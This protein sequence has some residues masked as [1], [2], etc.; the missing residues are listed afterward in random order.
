MLELTPHPAAPPA[1]ALAVAAEAVRLPHAVLELRYR[2]AGDLGALLIPAIAAPVRTDGLWRR[3]CL[4]AFV[5]GHGDEGYL[6]LNLSPSTEWA[7]YRFDRYRE[8]MRL[9]H[10][11]PA[12]VEVRSDEGVLDLSAAI[13]VSAADLPPHA[14]WQIGLS[15]VI[16]E[17]GGAISY[18]A[19]ANPPGRPDFHHRDGFV[20]ELPPA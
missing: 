20:L 18:W 13:D 7:A 14:P 6:E 8:G 4:E 2:L 11:A 9:G 19:L 12:D 5:R 10:S 3:T 17:M 1:A 16:E 15:A